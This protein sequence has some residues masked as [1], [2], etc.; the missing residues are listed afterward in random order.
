MP[1]VLVVDDDADFS[2]AVA[3]AIREDGHEVSVAADPDEAL[4]A[5]EQ[6]LPDVV[7]MD[8]MFPENP[9]AGFDL[10]RTLRRR[11]A[12]LPV[13]ML[14]A[15]NQQFPLGFSSQDIDPKWLPVTEFLEKPVDFRVLRDKL[16]SLLA[17]KAKS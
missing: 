4:A 13:L 17:E 16:R 15:I 10:A 5:I 11:W 6:R 8:V 12:E 1:Y 9:V 7:V 2:N 3:T 14:T